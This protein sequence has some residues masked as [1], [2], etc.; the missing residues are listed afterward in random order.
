MLIRGKVTE[1]GTGRPVAGAS[2]Q[3]FA[4]KQP[5][6][7]LDG[8]RDRREEDGS[9]RLAVPPGKGHLLG[10]GP[11]ARL[12][13]RRDRRRDALLRAGSPAALRFYAHDIIAYEVQA[14]EAPHELTRTLR[15]GKTLRGRVV[16]PA[17]ETVQD[18]VD[19]H[20]AADRS[21]R[22]S[23]WQDHNFIHARDGRFELH[24]FDPEK[25][26][27][28]YFL[29]A[30]HE[31][32]AAVELSGKQAGEELTDPPPA[33]RPGE[34]AVRRAR[35]QARRQAAAWPY[36]QIPDDPGPTPAFYL[37]R[38]ER[39]GG[40]RGLPAQRRSQALPERHRHRRRRPRHL[41]RPDPRCVVPDQRLVHRE[42]SEKGTPIRKDFTVKPGETLDLGEILVE[43]PPTGQHDVPVM[44][45][46]TEA[47]AGAIP[48]FTTMD[49][50][51]VWN[52]RAVCT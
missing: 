20:P 10:P 49:H 15:P 50:L 38:G 14:G 40:R 2:V 3:Y 13:P 16:G 31:W 19:P 35:R 21:H 33:V 9:F 44:C 17:G 25:A 45:V 8:G 39:V 23:T 41:S 5:R 26:A 42:R 29:D 12:R 28:V 18:A 27:P 30:D 37:E 7:M 47:G 6:D 4:M 34:G 46:R 43:K 22:T 51:L 24:G 32:G 52:A 1:E 48:V 36:F 11:D